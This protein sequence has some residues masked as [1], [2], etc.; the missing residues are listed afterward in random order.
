MRLTA[1]DLLE[2]GLVDGVIPEPLGAAHVDP[3]ATCINVGDAIE[4]AL[5]ELSEL[6]IDTLIRQR[7]E[8]FRK[9]GAFEE[10]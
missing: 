4:K 8:R 5:I 10:R 2:M 9:L 1:P 6:S 7:Y 3:E